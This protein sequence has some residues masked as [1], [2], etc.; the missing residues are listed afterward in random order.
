MIIMDTP[1]EVRFRRFRRA[2][3][4]VSTMPAE[5]GAAELLAFAR[6][7]GL[8][9]SWLQHA[10]TAREHFWCRGGSWGW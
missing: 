6:G 5:M 9:D 10:G 4:L 8:R 7:I 2:S 3:H 1:F